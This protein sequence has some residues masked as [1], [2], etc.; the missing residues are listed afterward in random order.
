MAMWS[1]TPS[2]TRW[3]MVQPALECLRRELSLRIQLGSR[4]QDLGGRERDLTLMLQMSSQ[5]PA[6]ASDAD[7]FDLILKP[8]S[9]AWV[10]R[11]PRFGFRTRISSYR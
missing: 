3:L 4:E 7:E 5:K 2:Q 1:R 10:A 6:S 11:W 8:A 9:S